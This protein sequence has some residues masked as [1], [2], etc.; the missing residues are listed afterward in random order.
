MYRALTMSSDNQWFEV[1]T[2]FGMAKVIPVSVMLQNYSKSE[3][4]EWLYECYCMHLVEKRPLESFGVC[5]GKNMRGIYDLWGKR[6][7]LAYRVDMTT[8]RN[9]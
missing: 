8:G 4:Q 9:V 1:E 3:V 5:I 2:D 7:L 6:L